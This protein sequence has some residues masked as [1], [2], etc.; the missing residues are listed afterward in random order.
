MQYEQQGFPQPEEIESVRRVVDT[1][2]GL[3]WSAGPD[4]S[5]EFLNKRWL[6]Y[7]G[8]AREQALEFGWQTVMHPEDLAILIGAFTKASESR[9]SFA[10]ETRIRRFDGIY[11][12][13]LMQGSPLCD[14]SGKLI[15]WYG[16]N[17]DIHDRKRAEEPASGL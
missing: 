14:E 3:V 17:T 10:V 9:E 1:I 11:R 5:A 8:L 7:T 6:E 16:T 4:G 2:P 13:F 12:W 15:Q